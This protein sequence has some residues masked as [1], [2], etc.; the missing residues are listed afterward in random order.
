[1]ANSSDKTLQAQAA[2][3]ALL[4]EVVLLIARTPDLDQLLKGCMSKLKWVFDF[5]RCT[6]AILN[7]DGNTY[8]LQTLLET[9]RDV[10]PVDEKAVSIENG[11]AGQVMS[12]RHFQFMSNLKMDLS[13][14]EAFKPLVD[15]AMED[16]AITSII[17]LPLVTF[18]NVLG[19]IMFATRSSNQFD[20]EDLK[21]A[22]SFA[23]HLALAIDRWQQSE[24]LNIAQT[25]LRVALDN[26]AGG[27]QF[28]DPDRNFILFN[29]QFSELYDLPDDLVKVG[30]S[31]FDVL[32]YQ[33]ERGDFGPGDT[34]DLI[35]KAVATYPQDDTVALER[36]IGDSERVVQINLTPTPEGGM[37]SIVTDI[38]ERKRAEA[39]IQAANKQLSQFSE[40][41]SEYL[42]PMLVDNL[43]DGRGVEPEVQF[44]TVFFADLVGSTRLSRTMSEDFFG[45]LIQE[46]VGDM[47]RIIKRHRGYL[48]DISGDGIF[49]YIGN[50]DS[51]GAEKD[52]VDAVRMALEMQKQLA[53][54][55]SKYQFLYKLPD[56]LAMRIGVSSGNALVGKTSGARAIYTANGDSVNLGAKLEQKLKE[57][58]G[59]GGILISEKTAEILNGC[60][61]LTHHNVDIEGQNVI[62]YMVDRDLST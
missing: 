49:G 61:A 13:Q 2:R 44:I 57:V 3:H 29:K 17:A 56:P 8:S 40:A 1:M 58:T 60:F 24:R 25:Q 54:L 39:Q 11:I 55:S 52:A 10:P 19:C 26:M 20:S 34:D 45:T 43:R 21:V 28:C 9:R 12:T 31:L 46:F 38:T 30:G 22:Q 27:M 6:L 50:F 32:R 62:A 47:Q 7:E 41:V 4:S 23:I 48:E 51:Q 14:L 53:E 37:V 35:K 16:V 5:E 18:D 15:T 42:D 33:A 59:A 36:T